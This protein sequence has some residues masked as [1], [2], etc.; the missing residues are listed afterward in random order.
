MGQLLLA[1]A[2]L[3]QSCFLFLVFLSLYVSCFPLPAFA[4]WAFLFLMWRT[5]GRWLVF[6]QRQP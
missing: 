1:P 5:T 6:D 3:F 4:F 2:L